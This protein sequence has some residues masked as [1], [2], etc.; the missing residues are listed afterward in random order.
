MAKRKRFR[1]K[2]AIHPVMTFLILVVIAIVL[3][4]VLAL[5]NTSFSYSA[6][7]SVRGEFYTTTESITSMLNL[8]GI[9][10]IF[11]NTVSNFAN[12]TVLSHLIII[13]LGIGI[14]EYSGFLK[15]AIGLLTKKV[16]KN[17]ITYVIV[18]LCILASIMDN[19]PFI[20]FIPLTAL[21]YKY[22]KRNPNVGIVCSF[23]A[24]T[25]G[26]G[27]SIFLTS[28]DSSLSSLTVLSAKVLDAGY[29]IG[30]FSMLFIMIAAIL[31]LSFAITYVTE[32]I[33]V[34]KL[35]KFD[36]EETEVLSEER[37]TK[38]QMRGLLFAGVGSIIYLIIFIYNVIPGLP[39]SGNFLNHNEV[40]YIDKLF[41]PESFFSNGFVFIVT[42]LFIIWG[43]LYGIGA[44]TI[45]N[46][47]EFVESLGYSLNGIGKM[48]L[49]IFASATFI[50]IFK[51]TNIGNVV[52]AGLTTLISSSGLTG[53]TLVIVLFITS[54]IATLFV[55]G[56][57]NKWMIM[58]GQIVP[59]FLSAGISGEFAQ[60][61]FRFGESVTLGL[62][63]VFAYFIV[64]LAY[65]EKYTQ[66]ETN[67]TLG[68]AIKYQMPY[69]FT[70]AAALLAI[71]VVWYLISLPLGIG[72]SI[73]V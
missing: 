22:G 20:A 35:P 65:L 4:G 9:K 51:Q 6:I 55:P 44:R 52:V 67:I 8:S 45:R 43:F 47:R 38:A 40:L 18:L 12:F 42:I 28:V 7:N 3:S 62:T 70:T 24:L 39:L 10:Y 58:S 15:T 71:I 13:L 68:N 2:I 21:I 66:D 46:N 41:G 25:C 11:S 5:F 50:S 72:G 31:I 16:R 17:V 53:L 59:V 73:A 32:N 56:S 27:L 30:S 29:S 37:L 64:Y 14:M 60:V 36:F 57:V 33:V 19:L 26:Y 1:E 23:A 63:P 34:N 69:S 61:I 49:F 54:G 48:L